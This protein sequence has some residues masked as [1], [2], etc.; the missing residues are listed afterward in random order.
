MRIFR[1]TGI[2]A[3]GSLL[4]KIVRPGDALIQF[5]VLSNETD[6]HTDATGKSVFDNQLLT[7]NA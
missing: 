5:T 1:I 7:A 2:G 4:A 3:Q 6:F